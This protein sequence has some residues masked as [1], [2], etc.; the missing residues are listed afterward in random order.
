VQIRYRAPAVDARVLGPEEWGARGRRP[1][2]R[3]RLRLVFVQPQRAVT[4]GQSAVV[5][6]G[7]RVLGGG[8]I[9]RSLAAPRAA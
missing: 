8:T 9:F 4:P 3:D 6:R 2:I 1:G 5:F 7:E